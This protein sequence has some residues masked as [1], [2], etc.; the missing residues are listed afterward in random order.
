MK[1]K[2]IAY[3]LCFFFGWLGIHRFYLH[4]YG[5]GVLYLLTFGGFG[6]GIIIDLF[7]LGGYVDT[8]NILY[9]QNN[10]NLTNNNS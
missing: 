2:F 6:I 1:S 5:T 7:T 4:K 10:A 8:Y 9:Q 3:L